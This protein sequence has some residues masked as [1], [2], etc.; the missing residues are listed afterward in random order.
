[1]FGAQGRA[2]LYYDTERGRATV[3]ATQDGVPYLKPA[4]RS[5]E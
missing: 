5:K 2:P 4:A 1:M 3:T